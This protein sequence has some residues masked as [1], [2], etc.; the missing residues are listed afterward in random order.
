MTKSERVKPPDSTASADASPQPAPQQQMAISSSVAASTGGAAPETDSTPSARL[1]RG[2][3]EPQRLASAPRVPRSSAPRPPAPVPPTR[4]AV[5]AASRRALASE[6]LGP[7]PPAGPNPKAND[8]TDP[9]FPPPVLAAHDTALNDLNSE[10]AENPPSRLSGLR[11]LL[12]SLGR[13]SLIQ[14]DEL[15]SA[16]ETEAEP[17]FERATVCPAYEDAIASGNTAPG[18]GLPARLSAQPEFLPPR[19]SAELEKEK[20]KEA[21]RPTPPRRDTPDGEEIQTLPSWRGQYRKKRYPPI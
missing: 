18:H 12:V 9:S 2:R 8:V 17:R 13:R 11:N 20:V 21:V 1:A 5:P 4:P 6:P 15:Q 7:I 3:G 16:L 10:P 19:P 14:E